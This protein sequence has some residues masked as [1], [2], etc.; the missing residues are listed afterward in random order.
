MV[1]Q[2]VGTWGCESNNWIVRCLPRSIPAVL[3]FFLFRSFFGI[4]VFCW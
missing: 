4:Y 2:W 3:T 1:V